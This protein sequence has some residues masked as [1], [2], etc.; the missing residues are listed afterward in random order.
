[1]ATYYVAF[2]KTDFLEERGLEAPKS[3]G[4]YF[5]IMNILKIEGVNPVEKII[6][7]DSTN[8]NKI[9]E[10]RDNSEYVESVFRVS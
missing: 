10:Y 7:F 8:Q 4:S 1:M 3:S 5:N 2:T 9:D 6:V